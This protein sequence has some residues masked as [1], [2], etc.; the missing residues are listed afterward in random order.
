MRFIFCWT[1]PPQIWHLSLDIDHP[2]KEYAMKVPLEIE[3]QIERQAI[4]AHVVHHLPIIKA[5]AERI[6]LV[7][8][9]MST[10]CWVCMAITIFT[11]TE[12]IILLSS[13]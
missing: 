4:D 11:R 6:G 9:E 12:M 7:P 8:I 10:D 3:Q 13:L 5:Y 2:G 1:L